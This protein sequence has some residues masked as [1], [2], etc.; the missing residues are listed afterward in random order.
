MPKREIKDEME[1]SVI[2][3]NVGILGSF[4]FKK[5]Q[6]TPPKGARLFPYY[7]LSRMVTTKG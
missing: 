7:Y 5:I 2:S 1:M 3:K 6:V 4:L